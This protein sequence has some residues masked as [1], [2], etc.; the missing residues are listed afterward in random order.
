[1]IPL[2]KILNTLEQLNQFKFA[3]GSPSSF[4]ELGEQGADQDILTA[5]IHTLLSL[6]HI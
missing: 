2:D 5:Q 1:M 6:I 4:I 3:D